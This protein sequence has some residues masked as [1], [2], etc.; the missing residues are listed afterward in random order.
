MQLKNNNKKGYVAILAALM[1]LAVTGTIASVLIFSSI[2]T[3]QLAESL[4]R[5]EAA[6]LLSESCAEEIFLRIMRD[7]E[8]DFE[9]THTFSLPAGECSVSVTKEGTDYA[10]QAIGGDEKYERN[11]AIETTFDGT[12]LQV[13]S[14][15]ED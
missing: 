14:W 1:L 15:K 3:S 7:A 11:V 2:G 13:N 12:V 6:L 4:R 5:G 9:G 8:G 10:I